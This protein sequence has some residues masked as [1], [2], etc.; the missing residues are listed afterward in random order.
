MQRSGE[1][2]SCDA[3]ASRLD[4]LTIQVASRAEPLPS[5][6]STAL[7]DAILSGASYYQQPEALS[8]TTM[9][10]LSRSTASHRARIRKRVRYKLVSTALTPLNPLAAGKRHGRPRNAGRASSAVFTIFATQDSRECWKLAF[11]FRS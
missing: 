9:C 5:I 4:D 10:F 7:M 6:E 2:Y 11:R 8:Q 1:S 3:R